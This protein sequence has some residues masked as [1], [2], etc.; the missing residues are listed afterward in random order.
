MIQFLIP[1]AY[2]LTDAEVLSKFEGIATT[3][4]DTLVNTIYTFLPIAIPV[5]IGLA[6]AWWVLRRFS[7]RR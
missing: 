3:T 2:A 4:R 5:V 6:L 7:V 1:H